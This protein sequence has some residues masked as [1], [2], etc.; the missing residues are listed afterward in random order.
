MKI[1]FIVAAVLLVAGFAAN[2]ILLDYS[3]IPD[4]SNITLTV[5]T[6]RELAG[7]AE[8]LPVRINLLP[9]ATGEFYPGMVMA[10]NRDK[11]YSAPLW[12][13]QVVY[14][15]DLPGGGNAIILDAAIDKSQTKMAGSDFAINDDNYDILQKGLRKA[16]AVI[17]THEHFDHVGGLALSP[18]FDELAGKTFLTN[19]Q[20]SS[21]DI[22]KAGFSKEKIE[23]CKRLTYDGAY[24]VFPGIILIKTPGHTP[25]HQMIYVR[26]KDG[27]EYLIAGDIAWNM[28]NITMLK[29]RP[30]LV[31]FFLGENRDNVGNQL[32]WLHD[33]IYQGHKEI[34]L[35]VYHDQNQHDEYVRRGSLGNGFEP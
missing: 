13:Y 15:R 28:D 19:E 4:K 26:L 20:A 3:S 25:G 23:K 32:R 6:L 30:L 2:K 16:A 27:S 14:D 24:A 7:N 1:F 33:E 8:P 31:S 10:G 29:Q 34:R 22:L 9:I 17:F 11:K 35:L 12:A 18:F 21:P 5:N